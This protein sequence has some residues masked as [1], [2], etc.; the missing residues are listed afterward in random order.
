SNVSPT[1]IAEVSL[2][3]WRGRLVTLNQ[4]T[5]VVG[6]LA[7]Q[8]VNWLIAQ[9]VPDGATAEMIRASWNGQYGWRWM[10]T[11]VA[12]PSVAFFVGTFFIPESPRWLAR[13]GHEASV[14]KILAR[15]GGQRYSTAAL[16]E[17]RQS[18][19]DQASHSMTLAML[20][21][22]RLLKILCMGIA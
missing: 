12:V 8:I 10:F 9:R 5:I 3:P 13:K 21:K 2:A 15:I 14:G 6:I 16:L 17:I 19:A 11:A 20:L 1:Y 18:L 22:P 4:L 7:A